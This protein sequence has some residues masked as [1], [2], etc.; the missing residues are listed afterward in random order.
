MHSVARRSSLPSANAFEMTDRLNMA[1]SER[2]GT[3]GCASSTTTVASSGA[4]D[5]L[6]LTLGIPLHGSEG[7]GPVRPGSFA[8]RTQ[9]Y[10]TS[11]DVIGVP[12]EKS[13]F[14]RKWNV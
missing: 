10:K 11:A 14:G 3:H 13:T 5:A 7:E 4:V 12:S 6:D 1:T 2:N 9:E 8:A